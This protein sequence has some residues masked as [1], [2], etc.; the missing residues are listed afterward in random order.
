[1]S[2]NAAS[3]VGAYV[4]IDGCSTAGTKMFQFAGTGNDGGGA[5]QEQW[6]GA[7]FLDTTA[8]TSV[9]VIAEAGNLDN[10]TVYVYASE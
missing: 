6:I 2:N 10:G 7:G 1:M 8:V 3:Q 4:K 9:S 5:N